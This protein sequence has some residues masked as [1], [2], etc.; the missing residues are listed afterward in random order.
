[1][2]TSALLLQLPNNGR[3]AQNPTQANR[4]SKRITMRQASNMMEA[5]AFAKFIDLPLGAHLTIHWAYT[6]IGD[7]PDGKL[8]AKVREGLSKWAHRQR[9]PFTGIWARERMSRGQA[10]VVHCHLLFHLPV[11]YRKG[12]RLLQVEAAIYRLI[13][14]HGRRD[15]DKHGYGYWADE[16]IKLQLYDNPDGK[17]LIKGG[18]PD[19]WKRFGIRKEHRR[20]AGPHLRQALW[21]HARAGASCANAASAKQPR[22]TQ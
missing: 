12:A 2:H 6:D 3:A 5:V 13:R 8:F 1:M 21:L 9:F 10:E 7:D 11:E 20:F 15:S 17:Y 22:R 14:K 18:G 16:V 4:A 19:V